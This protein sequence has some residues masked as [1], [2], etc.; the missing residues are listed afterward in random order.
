MKEG[1]K[2]LRKCKSSGSDAFLALLDHRNTP[3]AGKQISSAHRLFNRRARSLLPM[4]A[5]LLAP[6]AVPATGREIVRGR[7][8]LQCC[9]SQPC[10]PT[11]DKWAITA[12]NR[13]DTQW[14]ICWGT[15][16]ACS[17]FCTVVRVADK[18]LWKSSSGKV[19][20][21]VSS[22]ESSSPTGSEVPSF[23]VTSPPKPVLRRSARQ[24]RPPEHFNGFDLTWSHEHLEH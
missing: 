24:R 3:F 7:D 22:Q 13:R 6:Q 8:A 23:V 2:I 21:P 10:S 18:F 14:D 15:R 1:K 5:N 20:L 9:A 17:L 12:I 4:T 19:S 11:F 16:G